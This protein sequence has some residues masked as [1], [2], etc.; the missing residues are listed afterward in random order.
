MIAWVSK[1]GTMLRN[2]CG[3]TTCHIACKGVIP[4]ASAAERWPLDTLWMPA[5]MI[6]E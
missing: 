1:S 4:S 5:R 2:A 3:S 6:S